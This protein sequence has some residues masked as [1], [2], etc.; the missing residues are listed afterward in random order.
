MVV[1]NESSP[2]SQLN[3][4]IRSASGKVCIS[5]VPDSSHSSLILNSLQIDLRIWSLR[6]FTLFSIFETATL[7]TPSRLPKFSCVRWA[8][9]LMIL[10]LSPGSL[11]P[12]ISKKQTWNLPVKLVSTLRFF[13]F[14]QFTQIHIERMKMNSCTALQCRKLRIPAVWAKLF[15]RIKYH[16]KNRLS[17]FGLFVPERV[18]WQSKLN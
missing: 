5:P 16:K 13:L 15:M 18:C 9:C 1:S 4:V 10:T 14:P 8:S 17:I 3:L 6:E 7:L 11:V 2:Y 12:S